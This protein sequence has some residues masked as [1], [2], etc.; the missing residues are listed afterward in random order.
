[1]KRLLTKIDNR[2][3]REREVYVDY[4]SPFKAADQILLF[5]RQFFLC[6]SILAEREG[7]FQQL[8]SQ[9]ASLSMQIS[10]ILLKSVIHT[11]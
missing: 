11:V 10:S 2:I 3:I 1:M 8:G 7:Y 9:H 6:L 5:G 4:V